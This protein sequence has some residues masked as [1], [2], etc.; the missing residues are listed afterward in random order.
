[1]DLSRALEIPGWTTPYQLEWLAKVASKCNVIVELGSMRGRSA[2]AMVDNSEAL[3]YC[4]DTWVVENSWGHSFDLFR[5]NMADVLD[6]I[7]MLRMLTEV[8][9]RQIPDELDMV[10]V[11]AGHSYGCVYSDIMNYGPKVRVG[12]LLCGHDYNS[13]P[14][15]KLVVDRLLPSA[16]NEPDNMWWVRKPTGGFHLEETSS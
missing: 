1:V 8:G 14:D 12:G 16:T 7:V 5:K 4:V 2:R 15:V 13:S 10:F 11:D 6:R 3:I 9:V